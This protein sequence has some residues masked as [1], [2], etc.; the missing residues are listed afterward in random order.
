MAEIALV[1]GTGSGLSAALARLFH[2]EG[3]TL[4]LAARRPDKLSALCT[5][6]GARAYPCDVA[7]RAD[8]DALFDKVGK[9]IGTPNLV[10]YNPSYRTRGP[11]VELDP[12]VVITHYPQPAGEGHQDHLAA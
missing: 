2:K 3:M 5:E 8:V 6:T 12:D 10:V 9:E 7:I 11:F 1:V 4:A